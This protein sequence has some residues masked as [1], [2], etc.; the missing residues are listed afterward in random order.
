MSTDGKSANL[1]RKL[2]RA[3]LFIL[4][5]STD[6]GQFFFEIAKPKRATPAS[7]ILANTR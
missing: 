3:I 1:L 7:L 4:L 5:R 2:S 6:R